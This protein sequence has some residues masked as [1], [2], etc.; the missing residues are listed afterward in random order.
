[1][2]RARLVL[3]IV[4][5]TLALGGVLWTPES[6]AADGQSKDY[7]IRV[8][9]GH[10]PGSS[11]PW[12]IR[13][14]QIFGKLV[15]ARTNGHV[16]VKIIMSEGRYGSDYGV[17]EKIRADDGI[18]MSA[19][20]TNSLGVYS[21]RMWIF[22]MP[23]L[24]QDYAHVLR[25]LDGPIGKELGNELKPFNLHCLS[26]NFSG[27]FM[28]FP[29]AKDVISHPSDLKGKRI[30]ITAANPINKANIEAL[31]AKPVI[32]SLDEV[33]TAIKQGR[34]DG[35]ELTYCAHQA[36]NKILNE[37]NHSFFT[38]MY[39]INE[40]FFNKLPR[41]YQAIVA[42]AATRASHYER[43]ATLDNQSAVRQNNIARVH[44]LTPQEREEF[45]AHTQIVYKEY[46]WLFGS[47]VAQ[48][49]S[50]DKTAAAPAPATPSS[51]R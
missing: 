38:T 31:G 7:L 17:L 35:I 27:G 41:E 21:K 23:Y 47:L 43:Q 39:V 1:M 51:P 37:T 28:I 2:N 15:E 9:L 11:S 34:I 25:V 5:A 16:H 4:F 26:Y 6:K 12:Y 50:L 33:N 8:V 20:A 42:D 49:R 10:N 48:I 13:A 18:E 19:V 36:R 40:A 30:G 24:F 45:I 46:D 14:T 44:R 32:I 29:M 3:C 22:E